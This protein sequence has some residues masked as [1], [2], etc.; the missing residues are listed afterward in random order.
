MTV[1]PSL[2]EFRRWAHRGNVLPVY[3]TLPADLETPFGALLKL[4][5]P[6]QPAFLFESVEGEERLARFSFVGTQPAAV[7]V[8]ARQQLRIRWLTAPRGHPRESVV[9]APDFLNALRV[10]M[11][12]YR[13][14]ASPD[15]PRFCGGLVGYLGYE[16]ISQWEPVP[17][18]SHNLVRVPELWMMLATS[19]AIFDH[20]RHQLL[21]VSNALLPLRATNATITRIY[22]QTVRI[23]EAMAR[24]LQRPVPLPSRRHRRPSSPVRSNLTRAQFERMVLRAKRYIRAG[25]IIQ[26]VLSQRFAR[27]TNLDP[28][29]V[30]RALRRLNPSPY[31]YYLACG[32]FTLVG[33]SPEL[34]VRVEGQQLETRPIAGTRP[35][36]ATP[37][38]DAR[39]SQELLRNRK[40]RAEHL[41]LVDLGRNDLG[42]VAQPGSVATPEF[43]LLE[44]YSHV[45]HLVSRVVARLRPRQDAF[46][47]LRAV[48]PA[49]TVAGAP[50]V[51]AMQIIAE[52]EP[53]QRGPYAGCVGYIG[54]SGNMDTCITIRTI[55][56]TAGMA[57]VQ[58]GA[59]IVADSMPSAEYRETLNKAA[60]MLQALALAE[61]GV[62]RP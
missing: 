19:M 35:R 8:G 61:Q 56:M 53:D 18:P 38:E 59:G 48:F 55:L 25:D 20:A 12:Q 4:S 13:Y 5:R 27:P 37:K 17:T 30:Y 2:R 50:K 60:A 34:L 41:M 46:D 10:W 7:L 1:V 24:Q 39:L 22:H 40:E 16:V 3:A 26:V 29:H 14:V 52:L 23:L 31:M 45:M 43:C 42:R 49:G 57:Y 47:V 32:T 44:K 36:G 54:F 33:S 28:F 11:R 58:A 6:G 51:R 21:L 62:E 15:L 9:R